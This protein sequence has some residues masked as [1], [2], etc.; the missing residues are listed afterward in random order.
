M[1]AFTE[2]IDTDE[3]IPAAHGNLHSSSETINVALHLARKCV[4]EKIIKSK[5]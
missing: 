5:L 1:E 4:Y 2:I 3:G